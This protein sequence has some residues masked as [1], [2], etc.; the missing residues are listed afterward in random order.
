MLGKWRERLETVCHY[1]LLSQQLQ[2]C[3]PA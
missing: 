1:E 3:I 2:Y